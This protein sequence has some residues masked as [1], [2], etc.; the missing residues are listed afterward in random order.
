MITYGTYEQLTPVCD[1][2]RKIITK[3]VPIIYRILQYRQLTLE[4]A[5][6]LVEPLKAQSHIETQLNSTVQLSWVSVT[7]NM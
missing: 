2:V 7:F 5:R 3:C 1:N 6:S 4:R